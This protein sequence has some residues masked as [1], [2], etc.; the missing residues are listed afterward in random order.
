MTRPKSHPAG[1]CGCDAFERSGGMIPLETAFGHIDSVVRSVGE[2]EDVALTKAYGRVLAEPVRAVSMVPPFDNS[3]MDG[4]ALLCADLKGNGPW[5]LPVLDTIAAGHAAQRSLPRGSAARILTGAPMPRGADTV[6]MQENV[7][8]AAD[9]VALSRRPSRGSNVRRAGDDMCAGDKI[10]DKGRRLAA[11]EIAVCAAVGR[12][13][14]SVVRPIRV[15]LL[16]TGDEVEPTGNLTTAASIND[17]NTPMLVS[18]MLGQGVDLV[19]VSRIGDNV[20]EL[21]AEFRKLG[22][23]ADIL[24]T[25]GGVSV[26]DA[27]LLPRV[28]QDVGGEILFDR[29]AIKPGKPATFGRL[30][31]T[32]WLGLPGN[33]VAAFVGWQLF[34]AR[35][36]ARLSG[37]A[38]GRPATQLAVLAKDLRHHPGRQEFRPARIVGTDPEGRALVSFPSKT[39]S[40]A[41]AHLASADGFAII[42]ADTQRVR[43]GGLVEF[44]PIDDQR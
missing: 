38:P 28:F 16:V 21:T 13:S 1:D 12:T 11:K 7:T 36:L 8:R 32:L 39:N 40:A 35:L 2:V 31:A 19:S 4:Y 26:G 44:L 3:A 14:V 5:I 6:V 27:D 9:T 34:G 42:G 37:L 17:V 10:L 15:A 41:V 24:V 30:G 29:V 33:P 18:Q 23:H 22:E 25:T 20:E 43:K